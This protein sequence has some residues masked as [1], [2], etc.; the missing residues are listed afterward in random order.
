MAIPLL[1]PKNTS[2]LE[3]QPKQNHHIYVAL[4]QE[5]LSDTLRGLLTYIVRCA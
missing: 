1:P 5:R 4:H 2:P 3:H